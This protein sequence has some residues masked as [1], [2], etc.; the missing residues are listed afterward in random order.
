MRNT[1]RQLL[2]LTTAIGSLSLLLAWALLLH[3]NVGWRAFGSSVIGLSG[4]AVGWYW[5]S[6]APDLQPEAFAALLPK[7]EPFAIW[8]PALSRAGVLAPLW[9]FSLV[10]LLASLAFLASRGQ[11]KRRS[12]N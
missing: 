1:R 10:L 3:I 5:E 2:A 9:V 4:G 11:E 6:V 12:I 8:W 7:A